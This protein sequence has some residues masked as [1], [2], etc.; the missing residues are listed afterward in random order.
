MCIRNLLITE[1]FIVYSFE[2]VFSFAIVRPE[3][4]MVVKIMMALFWDV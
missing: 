3:V 2:R 1:Q 4:L